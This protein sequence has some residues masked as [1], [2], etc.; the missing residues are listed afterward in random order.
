[1]KILGIDL[2]FSEGMMTWDNVSVPIVDF[3]TLEKNNSINSTYNGIAF[4]VDMLDDNP[5]KVRLF[6]LRSFG[7]SL[8]HSIT[9]AVSGASSANVIEIW[10]GHFKERI[11]V[12]QKLHFIGSGTSRTIVDARYASSPFFFDYSADGSTIKN[13]K[14]IR[15]ANTSSCCAYGYSQAGIAMSGANDMIID[16][17]H[18]ESYNGI[19]MSSSQNVVIKNSKFK[20]VETLAEKIAQIILKEFPISKIK[21]SVYKPGA[22]RGSDSV[23]VSIV[24]P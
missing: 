9:D 5:D 7:E 21:V 4:T 11:Y 24:R 22:M 16:N 10:P 1:M 15:S 20:L 12:N 14:A 8:Y 17:I 19:V 3:N 18:T 23:G 6:A 2:L 13:L